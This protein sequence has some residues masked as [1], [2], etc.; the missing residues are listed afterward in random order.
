M[1]HLLPLTYYELKAVAT[2]VGTQEDTIKG[3][4]IYPELE[5]LQKTV[6]QCLSFVIT[7]NLPLSSTEYSLSLEIEDLEALNSILCGEIFLDHFS[8]TIVK[9]PK[10][11]RYALNF[12]RYQEKENSPYVFKGLCPDTEKYSPFIKNCTK[13][14]NFWTKGWR[15]S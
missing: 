5:S 10:K 1:E 14:H 8:N 2:I 12:A 4:P 9:L 11:V 3:I 15:L 7:Q 6:K 13:N